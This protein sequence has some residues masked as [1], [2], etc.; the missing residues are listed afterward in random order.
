MTYLRW[1]RP[2]EALT[3]SSHRQPVCV[4]LIG[5]FAVTITLHCRIE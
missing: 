4:R 2:L 1:S 5:R 3:D